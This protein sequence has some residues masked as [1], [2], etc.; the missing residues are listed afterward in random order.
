[1]AW[2]H[3]FAFAPLLVLVVREVGLHSW[4]G[5]SSV[6]ALM[7][8]CVPWLFFH[9]SLETSTYLAIRDFVARNAILLSSLIVLTSVF[10]TSRQSVPERF[11]HVERWRRK[12]LH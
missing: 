5:R 2:D 7:V 8:F 6:L 1:V 9:N 12:A 4:L 11:G 3:Y 10:A